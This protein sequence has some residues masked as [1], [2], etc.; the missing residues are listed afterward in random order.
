MDAAIHEALELV[1]RL[2]EKENQS[3]R[4]PASAQFVEDM[5]AAAI[6]ADVYDAVG[7]LGRPGT[8][9]CLHFDVDGNGFCLRCGAK[10]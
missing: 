6:K 4:T 10:P 8:A 1:V 2:A 5:R 9:S 3:E 7:R